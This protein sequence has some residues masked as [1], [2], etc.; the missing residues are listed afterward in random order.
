MLT[1]AGDMQAQLLQHTALRY[2]LPVP[3]FRREEWYHLYRRLLRYRSIY[4][5]TVHMY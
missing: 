4:E 1:E 3:S 2:Y 5:R